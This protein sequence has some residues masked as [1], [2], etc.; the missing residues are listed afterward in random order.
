MRRRSLLK[1]LALTPTAA[2]AD[3]TPQQSA[4]PARSVDEIP[5][6]EASIPDLAGE[7]VVRFF[8]P[9]QFAA[10]QKLAD[11][12]M[13]ALNGTPGALEARAPEFLDFLLSQSPADRQKLYRDGLDK[14]AAGASF[15][16]P[17]RIPWTWDPP[18]D[19][20]AAFLRAA[21][22]DILNATVNSYEWA[23]VVSKRNRNAAGLG[24]YWSVIE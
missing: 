24:T 21:K 13:P 8:T 2:L 12:I 10:L 6:I 7:P 23:A 11:A 3:P 22:E 18:K 4:P 5:K 20:F 9:K 19:P 17:L 15:D 1:S 16:A 14:L